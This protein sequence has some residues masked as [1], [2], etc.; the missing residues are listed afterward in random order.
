MRDFRYFKTVLFPVA[1]LTLVVGITGCGESSEPTAA[2]PTNAEPLGLSSGGDNS[3]AIEEARQQAHD[4]TQAAGDMDPLADLPNDTAQET[5]Q[6]Y[7]T[8]CAAGNFT[9][10]AEFCHPDSPGTTKLINM[11]KALN[12]PDTA[13]MGVM[14]F[15]TEGLDQAML[16]VLEEGDDRWA[17]EVTLPGKAPTRI[18]VTMLDGEWRVLP[19]EATGLPSQ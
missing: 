9:R 18:E 11:Q 8:A 14:G 15:L 6:S 19:P 17:F 13:G 7:I 5:I 1:T 2:A 16:T 4:A 12:D 10:A 3:H